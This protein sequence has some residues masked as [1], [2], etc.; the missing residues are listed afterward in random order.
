MKQETKSSLVQM[1]ECG[2]PLAV[3]TNGVRKTRQGRKFFHHP[4]ALGKIWKEKYALHEVQVDLRG[5]RRDF[6]DS[7]IS[8]ARGSHQ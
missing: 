8:E 4:P 5:R 7:E 2:R 1:R 3:V 6:R